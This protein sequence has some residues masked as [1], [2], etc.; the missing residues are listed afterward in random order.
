MPSDDQPHRGARC[1]AEVYLPLEPLHPVFGGAHSFDGKL[2]IDFIC[3]AEQF[4]R[5]RYWDY[6]VEMAA[7]K[8]IE[9]SW[10]HSDE[11]AQLPAQTPG[12]L[13]YS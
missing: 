1:I 13:E 11:N 10:S 8:L 3:P 5:G 12:F 2:Y 4:G 7:R 9:L 6:L